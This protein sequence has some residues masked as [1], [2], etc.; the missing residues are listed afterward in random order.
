MRVKKKKKRKPRSEA[1]GKRGVT[2]SP[3]LRAVL[4]KQ[5]A[6]FVQKFGREPGLTEPVFFDPSADD[7]QPL[8]ADEVTAGLLDACERAGLDPDQVFSHLGWGQD[9]DA[10]RKKIQ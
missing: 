4:L 8:D 3:R 6:A 7:P 10:Y 5:R 9:L 2:M 1:V